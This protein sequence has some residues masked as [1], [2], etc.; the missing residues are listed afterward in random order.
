M[1]R[2]NMKMLERGAWVGGE[3]PPVRN[4]AQDRN[5]GA[6]LGGQGHSTA[7]PSEL[8]AEAGPARGGIQNSCVSAQHQDHPGT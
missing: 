6:G 3:P 5:A 2:H 8:R 7:H 4:P 1:G